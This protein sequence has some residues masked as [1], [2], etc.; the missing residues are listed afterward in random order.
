MLFAFAQAGIPEYV[1]SFFCLSVRSSE[2]V[3]YPAFTVA[4]VPWMGLSEAGSAC[5][6]NNGSA[7][8]NYF[9]CQPY[10]MFDINAF[11]CHRY[12]GNRVFIRYDFFIHRQ[13]GTFGVFQV[14]PGRILAVCYSKTDIGI[15][16]TG[17]APVFTCPVA[18]E[19]KS[20]FCSIFLN[21]YL[22]PKRGGYY[23]KAKRNSLRAPRQGFCGK[24]KPS[25]RGWRFPAKLR[26]GLTLP[27]AE[28]GN[29]LC[30]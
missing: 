16:I 14:N 15:G 25:L 28:A 8:G 9:P 18:W 17:L 27:E 13:S 22:C 26:S 23:F 5:I 4:V 11:A 21:Y 24:Y 19:F 29:Y 12:K 7:C 3:L 30:R 20:F 1:I 6:H 2:C 10:G